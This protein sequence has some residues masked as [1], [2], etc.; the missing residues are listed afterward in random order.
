MAAEKEAEE[1]T[2]A[3]I[4]NLITTL[5]E[6]DKQMEEDKVALVVSFTDSRKRTDNARLASDAAIDN[7][8]ESVVEL[9]KRTEAGNVKALNLSRLIRKEYEKIF[10]EKEEI[11]MSINR[12]LTSI[13]VYLSTDD[14]IDAVDKTLQKIDSISKNNEINEIVKTKALNILPTATSIVNRI[15]N[16]VNVIKRTME[17]MKLREHLLKDNYTCC[18][19]A[20]RMLMKKAKDGDQRAVRGLAQC[21]NGDINIE[22]DKGRT[23]LY[24]ATLNGHIGVVYELLS[25]TGIDTNKGRHLD[26]MTPFSVASKKGHLE[27]LSMYV[28]HGDTDVKQGWLKNIWTPEVNFYSSDAEIQEYNNC[29]SKLEADASIYGKYLQPTYFY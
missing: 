7:Y 3:Q 26:G 15:K 20:T 23:P 14:E 24:H 16:T 6:K 11:Q 1:I 25:V 19:N 2:E 18:L 8:N 17:A 22:D 13:N 9:E 28:L 10:A 4:D 27:I 29:S 5:N 12:H 21:P